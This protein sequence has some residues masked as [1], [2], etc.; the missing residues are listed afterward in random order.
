MRTHMLDVQGPANH[1]FQTWI[2]LH[3][4]RNTELGFAQIP[5]AW[6]EAKP[7]HVHQREHV[8]RE[9]GGVRP[10]ADAPD[11]YPSTTGSP[12]LIARFRN[13]TFHSLFSCSRQSLSG[14]PGAVSMRCMN[15][16]AT[17]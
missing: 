7:Q 8:V 14:Q 10:K 13:S 11:G 4:T 5:D 3:G 17:P 16:K 1:R 9:A 15:E 6:R 12:P 2:F